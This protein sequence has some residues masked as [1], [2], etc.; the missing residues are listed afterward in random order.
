[1]KP[2]PR[3]SEAEWEVMTVVWNRPPAAASDVVERL[4]AKRAWS[5][6]TIR[7]LLDRLVKKKALRFEVEGKR[8]LY[9]PRVTM[10]ACVRKESRSFLQRVF[11]GEPASMLIHLVKTSRL[12]SEEIQELKRI[13][14]EKEK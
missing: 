8:Y 14:T 13:L 5:S 2:S 6:R 11:G 3:I 7:T 9:W 12:S 10:Q 1:M 4:R